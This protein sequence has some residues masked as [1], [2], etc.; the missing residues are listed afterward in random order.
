MPI[1]TAQRSDIPRIVELGSKSLMEGP[2]REILADRPDVTTAL[3]EK[4]L[5]MEKACILVA[6][7]KGEIIGMFAFFIFDHYFS[8]ES[9]AGETIWYVEKE[10]R[11]GGPGLQLLWA[12]EELAHSMGA[13]KFQL[14]APTDELAEAYRKLRGYDKVETAFQRDIS[15]RKSMNSKELCLP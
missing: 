10:H 9:V 15:T 7:E 12:A 5:K 1:R 3:A 11:K 13:K 6:E 14:T 2:Y 4:L 8:G